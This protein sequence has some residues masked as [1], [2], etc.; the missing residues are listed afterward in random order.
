M[1]SMLWRFGGPMRLAAGSLWLL[2][3]LH[4]RA[5]HGATATNEMRLVFG[6]TWLDSAK[7]LVVPLILLLLGVMR[8]YCRLHP[9]GGLGRIGGIVTIVGLV[10]LILGVAVEF[11]S[12]PWGSYGVGFETGLP[13]VG[14]VIQARASLLI[15]IGLIMFTIALVRA[16][17]MPVW[18]APV[19]MVG[20]VTTFY[21][22]PVSWIPG[23]AW[24]LL[25]AVLWRQ[26]DTGSPQEAQV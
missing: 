26:R 22:T 16:R 17:I 2:I 13:Q 19:L 12:F 15:T 7:F 14:G 9:P 21:L 18:A 4:Q 5:T 11:W 20:G 10:L 23:I 8:L 24:L 1:F 25:G 3:W 6:L